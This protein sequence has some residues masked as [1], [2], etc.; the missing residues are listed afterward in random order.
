[1]SEA[2]PKLPQHAI[3]AALAVLAEWR[4]APG[5]ALACPACGAPGLRIVDRSARP[6]TAWFALE[7]PSCGLSDTIG[8]PLGGAG[9]SWS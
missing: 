1:M 7:C 5:A 2:S 4:Q 9:N 3:K 6:H 8:Y